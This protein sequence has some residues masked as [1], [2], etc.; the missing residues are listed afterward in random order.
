MAVQPP[1]STG[2]AESVIHSLQEPAYRAG[3]GRPAAA[4]ARMLWQAVMPDPQ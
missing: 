2:R 1:F 3:N 4:I